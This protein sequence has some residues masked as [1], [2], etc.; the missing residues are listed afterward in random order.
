MVG[1]Q[2]RWTES[3][4]QLS[5]SLSHTAHLMLNFSLLEIE[6]GASLP[7]YW[8]GIMYYEN[9]IKCTVSVKYLFCI[10]NTYKF[11]LKALF[12]ICVSYKQKHWGPSHLTP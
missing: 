2:E 8:M 9:I 5:I 10:I 7:G 12:L 6:Q 11:I 1:L 4:T 3:T